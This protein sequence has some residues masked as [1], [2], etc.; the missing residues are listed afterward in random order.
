MIRRPPRSTRTDTLF[1][2][3]TLFRSLLQRDA[4]TPIYRIAEAVNLS[5]SACSRRI[6]EL[7]RLGYISRTVAVLDREKLG[8]GLTVFVIVRAQHSSDW[9][10]RIRPALDETPEGL[11]SK[12]R[13]CVV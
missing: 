7:K 12:S 11:E 6:A 4:E 1:P 5:P 9:L 10:E 13:Q 2:Y 8:L 3:T